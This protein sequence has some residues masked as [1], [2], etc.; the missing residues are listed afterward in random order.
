MV[1]TEDFLGKQ[2]GYE[3]S[4]LFSLRPA[5]AKAIHRITGED[6]G[7]RD[8]N[9]SF[10]EDCKSKFTK[11]GQNIYPFFNVDSV[12]LTDFYERQFF[13][14]KDGI[15]SQDESG[16]VI[17]IT[18]LLH[19]S[20]RIYNERNGLFYFSGR[21]NELGS[22]NHP[23]FIREEREFQ[24]AS[25][26]NNVFSMISFAGKIEIYMARKMGVR[27]QKIPEF[28]SFSYKEQK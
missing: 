21:V 5:F 1:E 18:Q 26:I 25:E 9:I 16:R 14:G 28:L 20:R 2:I 27:L 12:S 23:N 3:T 11:Y 15:R 22:S 19:W 7:S 4:R 8:P 10:K 6:L 13:V 17:E 24:I